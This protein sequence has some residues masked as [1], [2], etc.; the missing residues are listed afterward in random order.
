MKHIITTIALLALSMNTIF[1][2]D[3]NPDTRE[4][5]QIGFKAGANLSNVYDEKADNF[6]ANDKVG[7]V[8][9]IFFS[10]PINKF[11]GIQPEVLFSQ[12]GFQSTRTYSS[13]PFLPNYTVKYST[14]TNHIDIPLMVQIK[15]TNF[16]TIVLGPQYSYILSK[17]DKKIDSNGNNNSDTTNY[18]NDNLRKNILCAVGGVDFN[19]DHLVISG[20]AG[21]DLQDNNGDGSST[22]P[23]YKNAWYQLT[24]GVKF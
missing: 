8:G 3:N 9:G 21:W 18:N 11:L 14:T 19:I 7:F 2:Q 24:V 12:K 23:R 10:I 20:R 16:M 17:V 6:V 5:F 13:G 1:A 4:N 22:N 15:P